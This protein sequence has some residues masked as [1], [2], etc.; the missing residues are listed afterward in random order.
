MSDIQSGAEIHWRMLG[1]L[2]VTREEFFMA[3]R[4]VMGDHRGSAVHLLTRDLPEEI[5]G[6]IFYQQPRATELRAKWGSIFSQ[7]GSIDVQGAF[8]FLIELY[9]SLEEVDKAFANH[10]TPGTTRSKRNHLSD[11][12]TKRPNSKLG[13]SIQ[14]TTQG[15]G[16]YNCIRKQFV[17]G[18]GDLILLSPDA[19]YDYHRDESCHLWEHQWVYFPQEERWLTWLQWPEIG[20]GIYHIKADPQNSVKL[21][22]LFEG[23]YESYFESSEPVSALTTNIFE[24]LLIRCHQLAPKQSF[25]L[26]DSRITLVRDYIAR[27]FDQNFTIDTLSGKVGLSPARLSALFKQQTGSTPMRWRDERRMARASQLLLQTLYPVS[28][29]AE[30]VGYSDALYFS[31]CFS[32]HLNCSPSAYRDKRREKILSGE[33]YI[34]END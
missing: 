28:K 1:N 14:L 12:L 18:P 2:P 33:N 15:H 11:V 20:P 23:V 5:I 6:S 31:R 25:P 34:P 29:I 4:L 19:L 13:W 9:D 24:Q 16:H 30:L 8:Q 22:G 10:I 26:M 27:N 32:R 17:T 21:Q 7:P 3:L